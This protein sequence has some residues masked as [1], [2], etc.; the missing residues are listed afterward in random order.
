[1]GG[2]PLPRRRRL[3]APVASTAVADASDLA[4]NAGRFPPLPPERA[5]VWKRFQAWERPYF[6][7][8]VGV[9]LE[10]LRTD[11]ARMRLPF[12]PELDQPAGVV[13]GGAIA[14]LVDTVVVPAIA[15]GYDERPRMV[16]VTMDVQYRGAVVG[17]DMVAEGW[18]E[19]RGRSIV[20]CRADVRTAPDK[21][22]ATGT[23][24]YKVSTGR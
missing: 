1:M 13:H 8:F 6:P 12:R 17:E 11:Y 18:V 21:L 22:V 19:Q 3:T 14:T 10:E 23:L 20:F 4:P 9:V 2:G 15:T 24:V 7:T 16:T 5:E